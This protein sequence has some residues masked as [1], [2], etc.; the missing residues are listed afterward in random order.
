[1]IDDE[2]ETEKFGP[3]LQLWAGKMLWKP[4]GVEMSGLPSGGSILSKSSKNNQRNL[5]NKL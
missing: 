4:S 1:M 5:E 3:K 2:S